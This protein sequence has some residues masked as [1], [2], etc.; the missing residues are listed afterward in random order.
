M[1][2]MGASIATSIL[3]FKKQRDS[4]KDNSEKFVYSVCF[5]S[6][7]L[8]KIS[9]LIPTV[10][11]SHLN[12]GH[13]NPKILH[14]KLYSSK[15]RFLSYFWYGLTLSLIIIEHRFGLTIDY[16]YALYLQ[17]CKWD[18]DRDDVL[19]I[20]SS[21]EGKRKGRSRNSLCF[22]NTFCT[23]ICIN[24]INSCTRCLIRKN[25]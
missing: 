13:F 23:S 24:T 12:S 9:N 7:C 25:Y 17:H 21:S 14:D 6:C 5:S 16:F 15:R 2:T 22:G 8:L 1:D 18:S 11:V 19:C 4:L 10:S 3:S 20:N